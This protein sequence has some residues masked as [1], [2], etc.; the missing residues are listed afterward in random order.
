M[1]LIQVLYSTK[2]W[3]EKTLAVGIQSAQVLSANV[4]F[5]FVQA[6]LKLR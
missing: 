5:T 4:L 3:R 2:L 1:L 6:L